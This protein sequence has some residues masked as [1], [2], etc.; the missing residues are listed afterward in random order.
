MD[1][2]VTDDDAFVEAVNNAAD[3]ELATADAERTIGTGGCFA[4]VAVIV[5]GAELALFGTSI[6]L[7]NNHV[8]RTSED[9]VKF[10][11]SRTPPESRRSDCRSRRA[12]RVFGVP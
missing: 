4:L 2:D 5:I 1:W 11:S 6:I 9:M 7:I 12:N 10:K 3:D 8:V